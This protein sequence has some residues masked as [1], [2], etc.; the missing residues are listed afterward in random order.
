M[1]KEEDTN[2]IEH[3]YE[4]HL[5]AEEMFAEAGDGEFLS[6]EEQAKLEEKEADQTEQAQET[7]QTTE[8]EEAEEAEQTETKPTTDEETVDTALKAVEDLEIPEE[9]QSQIAEMMG[10]QQPETTVDAQ[11]KTVP[12]SEHIKL[13]K[14]AQAAEAK[15]QERESSPETTS[16]GGEKPGVESDD[17]DE[18][19]TKGAVKKMLAEQHT[20]IQTEAQKAQ[21][22]EQVKKTALKAIATEAEVKKANADYAIITNFANEH[23]LLTAEDRQKIFQS[24]NPAKV[25]YETCKAKVN[26]MRQALGIQT[27]ASKKTE[28]S[29]EESE[30][31]ETETEKEMSDDEI[32]EDLWG[33]PDLE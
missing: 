16:T 2:L 33:S 14:R 22:T 7:E 28:T 24:D 30:T 9:S 19:L 10:I 21:Q 13:R 26:S 25:Y 15:L 20:Q 12:L 31:T 32:F 23:S 4:E 29:T 27:P 5:D 18:W 6:E 11:G 1:A 8:T 3:N 17:D